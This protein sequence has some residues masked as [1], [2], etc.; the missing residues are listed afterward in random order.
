MAFNGKK[1]FQNP[2]ALA[3]KHSFKSANVIKG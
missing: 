1:S 3:I 2:L